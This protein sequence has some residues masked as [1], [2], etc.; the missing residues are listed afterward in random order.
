MDNNSIYLRPT[1]A[2]RLIRISVSTLAKMR[3]RGDGP[4]FVKSGRKIVLYERSTLLNWLAGR[5]ITSTE[6]AASLR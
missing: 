5:T 4:P 6:E 1:E 2:S 3:L